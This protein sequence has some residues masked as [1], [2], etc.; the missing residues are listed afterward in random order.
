MAEIIDFQ[1]ERKYR[2]ELDEF[3]SLLAEEYEALYEEPPEDD[4]KKCSTSEALM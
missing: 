3:A 1:Y 2:K 4:I